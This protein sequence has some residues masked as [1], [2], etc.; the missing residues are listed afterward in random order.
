M[1]VST[2]SA[3]LGPARRLRSAVVTG[4]AGISLGDAAGAGSVSAGAVSTAIVSRG[5]GFPAPPP[6]APPRPPLARR[7]L[8][9]RR[10]DRRRL[11]RRRLLCQL[12]DVWRGCGLPSIDQ[13]A[14][15]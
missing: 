9:R 8:D 11:D 14:G 6:R 7:R 13:I 2:G 5:A 4:L 1:T 10:L 15:H 12:D 3:R